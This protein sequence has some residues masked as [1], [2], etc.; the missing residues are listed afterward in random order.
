MLSPQQQRGRLRALV[1]RELKRFDVKSTFR[2]M[3]RSNNQYANGGLNRSIS[4]TRFN[5][6]VTVSSS[7]D[8][9]TGVLDDVVVTLEIP[10]GRYGIKLDSE[11]GSSSYA[12]DQMIPSIEGLVRWIKAKNIPVKSYV[13]ASLKDGSKKTYGPYTGRT[14]MNIMAYNIQQN[15]IEENELRTR[16]DYA[17]EIRL[18]LQDILEVAISD[19]VAEMAEDQY[20]DVLVELE[21]L[22]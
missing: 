21:E 8:P 20:V 10:W 15:I 3:L 14:G 5:K 17:D 19:W 9:Q 11:Y 6:M 1:V 2:S 18:Q 4:A 12:S 7:I 22:Y 16:Y 13:T